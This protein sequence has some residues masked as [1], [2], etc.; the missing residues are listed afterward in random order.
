[1]EK[2]YIIPETL[3]VKLL[4]YM[5]SRPYREVVQGVMALSGLKELIEESV[6]E[7]DE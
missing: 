2:Q 4:Q 7:N 5:E 1:M 3:L 6:E